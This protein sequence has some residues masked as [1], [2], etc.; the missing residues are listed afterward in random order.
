MSNKHILAFGLFLFLAGLIPAKSATA[1]NLAEKADIQ[2]AM[3]RYVDDNLVDG[4]LLYLDQESGAVRRLH[5]VTA[6]PMILSMAEH[7]ILCFDFRDDAG[8][9]I[10]VDYYMAPEEDGY[11]VFH[12]AIDDRELLKR[13]MKEGQV[14]RVP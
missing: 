3:Q 10:P 14:K 8:K 1:L 7:Y 2:A 5:P 6:H 13:L 12:T 9:K 4:A 11:V